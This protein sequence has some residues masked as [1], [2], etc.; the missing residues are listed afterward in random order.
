MKWDDT[1][2]ELGSRFEGAVERIVAG[3]AGLVRGPHGVV[4]VEG[5]APGDRAVIEITSARSGVAR[6]EI[7]T[8]V[9]A[10]PDRT[11]PPCP[12]YGDCGGCDLQHLTYRAQLEAKR[13]IVL[14]ALARIGQVTVPGEIEVFA[15]Q[16][17]LGSRTRVELH[18]NQET[19]DVGF[20]AKRSRQVVPIDRCI[21]SCA[22]INSSLEAIRRSSECLPPSIHL[23]AG[24]NEVRSDP[25]VSGLR[26]GSL[27]IELG[28]YEY[29]ADPGSFFQSSLDLLPSLV[30]RVVDWLPDRRQLAWDLYC[31]VGLFSLPL[32]TQFLRVIGVD[33]DGR[34]IENARLT[35][36]RNGVEHAEFIAW[37]VT[38]WIAGPRIHTGRPDFVV[39]DPPR[40][41][42]EQKLAEQLATRKIPRLTYVSC[43][44][45]TLARDLRILTSGRLRLVDVAIFDLFPQTHHIETVARLAAV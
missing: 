23:L 16:R 35:A 13:Q 40:K 11:L 6:G 45:T 7:E 4:L 24:K 10:S 41:G 8:L 27:W 2:Y 31:G 15:A 42:L 30:S 33:S 21:A 25:A 36:Q 14:D 37:D 20:F 28:E 22:E 34:T 29:L 18:T 12:W 9:E 19:G 5:A 3:G 26:G 38:K 39:V 32:A 17:P 1:K 43:D 44:P